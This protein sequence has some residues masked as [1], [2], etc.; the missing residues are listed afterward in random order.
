LFSLDFSG[1]AADP[2]AGAKSSKDF[3]YLQQARA[4]GLLLFLVRVTGLV[5]ASFP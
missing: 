1:F 4:S 5:T 2:T 3:S